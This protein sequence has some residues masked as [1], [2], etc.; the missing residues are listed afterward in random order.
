M[1]FACT[2]MRIEE[3]IKFHSKMNIW[4]LTYFSLAARRLFCDLVFSIDVSVVNFDEM[5]VLAREP[6]E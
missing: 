1:N 5:I 6:G 2:W 4:D 3:K